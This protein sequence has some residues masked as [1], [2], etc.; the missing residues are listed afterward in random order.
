MAYKPQGFTAGSLGKVTA[1]IQNGRIFIDN[2]SFEIAPARLD[3]VKQDN[4]QINDEVE[5]K[6]AKQGPE[7]DKIIFFSLKARAAAGPESAPASATN[8]PAVKHTK[9]KKTISGIYVDQAGP[10]AITIRESDG[11][12]HVYKAGLSVLKVLAKSD[13]PIKKGDTAMFELIENEPDKWVVL[14]I[15]P[16]GQPEGFKTGK[17]ILEEN[18]KG[19]Q[20]SRTPPEPAEEETFAAKVRAAEDAKADKQMK[21]NAEFARALAA[22]NAEMKATAAPAT[23]PPKVPEKPAQK[24]DVTQAVAVV[25]ELVEP[26][27]IHPA[28]VQTDV[29][30]KSYSADDMLLLRNVIAK[31]CTEPEFRLLMYTADTYG[32]DPLLKQIWAVKRNDSTPALIFAGRDGMLAI[33]H[34]SG[35]FDGMQSGVV[36][37]GQGKD[38]VPVTA[39]C[40]V[41][42]K[43]MSHSFKTDVP[44]SEYNTGFSVWKSNPSAMILKVAE[45][46]CLR[47][48]FSVSGLYSPEEISERA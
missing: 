6:V 22:K 35:Q 26:C 21:E 14:R 7:K 8:E 42:R 23:V 24:G 44:F 19:I 20:P 34:R 45:S 27:N 46:V 5:Y 40:E 4:P 36:Y 39:W 13:S 41:W 31:G 16:A 29:I 48:A 15:G 1:P 28:T 30:T 17:E 12:N 43:D 37:E 10:I 47:K 9:E 25:A 2:K 3:R 18:M 32:L 33:A 11:V 38:R